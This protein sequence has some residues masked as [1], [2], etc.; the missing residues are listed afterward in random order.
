MSKDLNL[1][2]ARPGKRRR[3]TA[4]QKRALLDEAAKAG[5]SIS[6]VARR[7]GVAPSVLFQWKRAM[8][9]AS[10]KSLERNER[11]VPESVKARQT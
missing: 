4:Q 6:E 5:Q 3:F 9:D 1:Q 11:V 8:D 7:Y 2:P 10:D